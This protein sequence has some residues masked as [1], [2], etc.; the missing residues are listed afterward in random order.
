M[1]FGDGYRRVET[2]PQATEGEHLVTL[3]VPAYKVKDNITRLVFP[4]TYE[5]GEEM[6]PDSFALFE[7][8]NYADQK[9]T[10]NF[11][12]R[13]TKIFDCFNLPASFDSKLYPSWK[14]KQGRVIIGR[15]KKGF[16]NVVNF[17]PSQAAT[18][19]RA[20]QNNLEEIY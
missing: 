15:D 2:K 1:A 17:L 19:A 3:G 9:E 5:N 7:V 13:A 6:Q 10:D 4:I 16:L 11:N 14:G 18:D 20:K 12:R 8:Q